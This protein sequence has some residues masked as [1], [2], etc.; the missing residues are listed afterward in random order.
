MDRSLNR[1]VALGLAG[2]GLLPAVVRGQ[3]IDDTRCHSNADCGNECLKCN[4][5]NRCKPRPDGYVC[6]TGTCQSGTCVGSSSA[7]DFNPPAIDET[8]AHLYI[9]PNSNGNITITVPAGDDAII[10]GPTQN[11][12]GRITVNGGRRVVLRGNGGHFRMDGSL[13]IPTAVGVVDDNLYRQFTVNGQTEYFMLDGVVCDN[14]NNREYDIQVGGGVDWYR[15]NC[16]FLNQRGRQDGW[17]ADLCQPY[18]GLNRLFVENETGETNYQ[19]FTLNGLST[20]NQF[21][22]HKAN[23]RHFEPNM[24]SIFWVDGSVSVD[25]QNVYVV[26][27]RS[28]FGSGSQSFA[29]TAGNPPGGD[30]ATG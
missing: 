6:S 22:I 17:H 26:S 28:F 19:G 29:V 30:F 18:N 13:P 20:I 4:S 3:V 14:P 8:T 15:R 24:S 25:A 16:L 21:H 23:Y 12:V 27:D 2:L 11:R 10:E 5:K 7:Y 1:R 9:I